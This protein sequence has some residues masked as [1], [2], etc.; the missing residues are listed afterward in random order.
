MV[1]LTIVRLSPVY[2][3]RPRNALEHPAQLG[4]LR[5]VELRRTTKALGSLQ[6]LRQFQFVERRDG[7]SFTLPAAL[8][9]R[10]AVVYVRRST[11]IQV[12]AS[13]ESSAGNRTWLSPPGAMG[14]SALRRDDDLGPLGQRQ[15][16]SSGG[17]M[18]AKVHLLL[19]SPLLMSL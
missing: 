14:S 13:L 9:N 10:K 19:I 3:S 2:Q 11:Q 7:N 6:G 8:L 4:V 1:F 16:G 5:P 17:K 12:R 15:R 18:M